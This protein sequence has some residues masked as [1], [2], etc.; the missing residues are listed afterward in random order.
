MTPEDL[1]LALFWSDSVRSLLALAIG[2]AVAG[3]LSS[4]YQLLTLQPPSFNLLQES[5]RKQA[6]AAVVAGFWSLMSGTVVMMALR[7][8]GHLVA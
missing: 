7:A 3:L 4:G 6:L 1:V 2:F 8:I 5:K